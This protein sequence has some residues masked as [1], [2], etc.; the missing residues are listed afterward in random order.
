MKHIQWAALILALAVAL[1]LCGTAAFASGEAS[2]DASAEAGAEPA[3]ADVT[4]T[5]TSDILGMVDTGNKTSAKAFLKYTSGPG[6]IN[7]YYY[8]ENGE[9]VVYDDEENLERIPMDPV[10]YTGSAVV[11]FGG[12][13]ELDAGNASVVL[14]EGS[15]YYFDD[16]VINPDCISITAE[17]GAVEITLSEGAIEWNDWDNTYYTDDNSGR[18]WS[19]MGGDGNGVYYINLAL[20]GVVCDGEEAG[21]II[22]PAAVYC[23]GR[24]C[25]DLAYSGASGYTPMTVDASYRSGLAPSDEVRWTWYTENTAS[26]EDGRPYLNDAYAD[27]ISVVWPEGTDASGITAEDVTITLSDG[28]GQKRVLETETAF[29]EYEYSVIA[30]EAETVIAVTYEQWAFWPV[31]DTMTITIG[32]GELAAANTFDVASVG[33]SMTQTGGGGDNDDSTTV[34]NYYGVT[35]LAIG[36]GVNVTY[37]MTVDVDGETLYYDGTSLVAG[38]GQASSEASS[39]SGDPAD[40]GTTFTATE[41]DDPDIFEHYCIYV[42]GGHAVYVGTRSFDLTRTITVDGVEYEAVVNASVKID[43]SAAELLP[44]YNRSS[45]AV[46]K[47]AWT[48]RYQS[49]W[50]VSS[51]QPTG[52]PYPEAYPY[53]FTAAEGSSAVYDALDPS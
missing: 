52:L 39:G 31:Y 29:G 33:T 50:D 46:P 42:G 19:I 37:T 18:E 35:G 9:R 5:V 47:W 15:G 28:Y 20:T 22:I 21:P 14:A 41:A 25:T 24:T 7:L 43:T 23:Y 12:A 32:N 17:D 30:D 49:G 13:S 8:N 40:D 26:A 51:P 44:G 38:S 10:R 36:N 27:Y 16:Y 34:R 11:A 4:V 48:I 45:A 53:G 3:A 1:S 2:S 6:D